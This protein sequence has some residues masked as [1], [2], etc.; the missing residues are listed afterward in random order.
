M[1]VLRDVFEIVV[2]NDWNE[3]VK[4]KFEILVISIIVK[5]QN[6]VQVLAKRNMLGDLVTCKILIK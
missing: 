3:Y 4:K 2:P 6:M 5:T 1:S